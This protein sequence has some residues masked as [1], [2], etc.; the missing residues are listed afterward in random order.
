MD[1]LEDKLRR[2]FGAVFPNLSGP[3]MEAASP[4]TIPSWDSLTTVTLGA[5]VEESFGLEIDPID[6]PDLA[7]YAA[8]VSYLRARRADH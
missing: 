3:E 6:L 5:L 2:C 1:D 8:V 4:E 7:S